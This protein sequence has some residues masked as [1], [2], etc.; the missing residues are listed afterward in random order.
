MPA[1]AGTTGKASLFRRLD[2]FRGASPERVAM[3]G[4]EKTK[5]ADLGHSDVGGRD[6]EDF[7]LG[8]DKSRAEQFDS[9]PRRPGI[10]GK[11]QRAHRALE[12]RKILQAAELG[13]V[14]QIAFAHDPGDP[15][16]EYA[17]RQILSQTAPP[18]RIAQQ[19]GEG[20][21]DEI[22]HGIDAIAFRR[23]HQL[24][25]SGLRCDQQRARDLAVV[26]KKSLTWPP[27]EWPI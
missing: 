7:R 22:Q 11:A 24:T 5:M 16:L 20:D 15:F 17:L 27:K 25:V 19:P 18:R 13:I 12:L 23:G 3:L 8:R 14:E 21:A 2:P 10:I 6:G 1:F 4:T 26:G 9:R